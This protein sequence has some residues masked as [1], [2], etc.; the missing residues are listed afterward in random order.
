M[1]DE[2]SSKIQPEVPLRDFGILCDARRAIKWEFNCTSNDG[3]GNWTQSA[4]MVAL[5]PKPFAEGS[6][7]FAYKMRDLSLPNAVFVAK[8][9][10]TTHVSSIR[11]TYF[12]DVKLQKLAKCYAVEYNKAGPPK[13]V[14]FLDTFVIE[15]AEHNETYAVEKYVE[16]EFIKYNNNTGYVSQDQRNTPQAFSHFTYEFS[17][18][19]L[20][21][22]DIQ[23]VD[24]RYTDPQIHTADS[25]TS[26]KL[27]SQGNWGKKGID[28]F[29][30]TH[31]C[32]PICKYLSLP[33]LNDLE[34]TYTGTL[35]TPKDALQKLWDQTKDERCRLPQAPG[36][37]SPCIS[38]EA[39][40]LQEFSPS[41][42]LASSTRSP[43]LTALLSKRST[44]PQRRNTLTLVRTLSS[45]TLRQ[46]A[47]TEELEDDG[48]PSPTANQDGEPNDMADNEGKKK[49]FVVIPFTDFKDA[50]TNLLKNV[51]FSSTYLIF[52][53]WK[54]LIISSY[55]FLFLF[56][57]FLLLN[58]PFYSKKKTALSSYFFTIYHLH[59]LP[60]IQ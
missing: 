40:P 15:M 6:M 26:S 9:Y 4:V 57:L 3:D 51:S 42:T 45:D 59:Y 14:D 17:K 44:K 49:E 39:D 37:H 58:D 60:I 18:K 54:I 55:H 28:N 10:K 53:F 7:R 36:V 12:F 8:K 27:F 5:A 1:P 19:K 21:I 25:R 47:G 23:G 24:D 13:P 52:L 29:I 56:L 11:D 31:V 34:D 48:R 2:G 41:F 33:P 46:D 32:N 20:I 22:V 16:G 43:A 50:L 38:T 35:P 30:A